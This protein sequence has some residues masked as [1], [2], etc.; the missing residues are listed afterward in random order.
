[1]ELPNGLP[2]VLAPMR[3]DTTARVVFC[4][5]GGRMG[6]LDPDI[7]MGVANAAMQMVIQRAG[8]LERDALKEKLRD[9]E[10]TIG[11]QAREGYS[12]IVLQGSPAKLAEG[13]QIVANMLTDTR[14]PIELLDQ[15][16]AKA[17]DEIGWVATEPGLLASILMD[18]LV[19]GEQH[20]Y[21]FDPLGAGTGASLAAMTPRHVEQWVKR[22]LHP[23]NATVVAVGPFD[24][25][26]LSHGLAQAFGAVDGARERSRAVVPVRTRSAHPGM[27][28]LPNDEGQQ[29]HVMLGYPVPSDGSTSDVVRQC[30]DGI[31]LRRVKRILREEKGVTYRV[32]SL[33]TA[34]RGVRIG[35]FTAAV[36][37]AYGL[38]ALATARSMV[39]DLLEGRAPITQ[40]ELDL[41]LLYQRRALATRF[42][43]PREVESALI[44][45]VDFRRDD[46][47]VHES[48]RVMEG[49]TSNE[50]N[51][52]LRRMSMS[53]LTWILAGRS[54]RGAG[55]SVSSETNDQGGWDAE[56]RL[57]FT[58]MGLSQFT[59]VDPETAARTVHAL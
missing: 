1:M 25:A 40:E 46:A 13:A 42:Q 16:R 30:I 20:P 34:T 23:S 8:A 37:N 2:L 17:R 10:L 19:L 38:D 59:T 32:D 56:L 43:D 57:Q 54:A 24:S 27:Y 39:S 50:V 9:L 49:L 11:S 4:F 22:Y 53:H 44:A 36:D 26:R 35:G 28:V 6:D 41:Y 15:A 55:P 14:L 7:G 52:A 3:E 18:Q 58:A 29:S 21:G 5:D 47:Q 12:T 31:I 48:A 51:Q 33:A 45:A